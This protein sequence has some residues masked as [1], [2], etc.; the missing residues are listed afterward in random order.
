[1]GYDEKK[2]VLIKLFEYE[3]PKGV[4]QISIFSY[5]N[6]KPKIQINRRYVKND[7]SAGYGQMGR[8]IKEEIEFII[9]KSEEILSLMNN[10]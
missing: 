3:Y 2:D 6:G 8:L 10:E 7:G 4:L 1:M 5:N 9:S